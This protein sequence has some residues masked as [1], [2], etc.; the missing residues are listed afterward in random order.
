M[1][2]AGLVT[3]GTSA[4]AQDRTRPP[5]AADGPPIVGY[6]ETARLYPGDFALRAKIDTGATT[7][8]LNARDIV[9]FAREGRQWV[10]FHV[11]NEE[12]RTIR[13]ERPVVRIVRIKDLSGPAIPR[14][15]IM[16][17]ICVAD[18]FRV[19]EVNL[20]DRAG[21]NYQLLVGRRFLRQ[22][23]AVDPGR[24]F[25]RP[26]RCE[27]GAADLHTLDLIPGLPVATGEDP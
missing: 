13:F 10:R 4:G 11:T 24:Q 22:T 16:L 5:S 8:S 19:T 6:A 23:L 2:A 14:P 26:P 17:G 3:L 9:G 21:F 18:V 12:N 20:S 1:L 15:V 27:I 7:S 25:T